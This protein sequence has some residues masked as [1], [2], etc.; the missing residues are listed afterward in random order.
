M[1]ILAK[2]WYVIE[3]LFFYLKRLITSNIEVAHEVL[4][5]TFYMRPAIVE[6]PL[7]VKTDHEI[8][9]L[10]NLITMTPG[11]L[12]LDI[13]DNKDKLYI[14]A[15]YI[16]DFDEFLNEIKQLEQRIDKIFD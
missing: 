12:S 6:V 14:H 1:K 8:L 7:E 16:D 5:P 4:T 13:S 9:I 3:F 15:M 10:V 11:T 2:T